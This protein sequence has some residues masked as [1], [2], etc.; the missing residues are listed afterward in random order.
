VSWGSYIRAGGCS[1]IDSWDSS[2][3]DGISICKLGRKPCE[4]WGGSSMIAGVALREL[5]EVY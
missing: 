4:N 5:G 3:I 1:R 2:L